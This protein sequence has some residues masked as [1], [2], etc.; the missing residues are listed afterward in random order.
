M[1]KNASIRSEMCGLRAVSVHRE[2]RERRRLGA[3]KAHFML[4]SWRHKVWP[5]MLTSADAI[6]ENKVCSIALLCTV[7]Y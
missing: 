2:G 6:I 3:I 4:G 5:R 1:N 7:N